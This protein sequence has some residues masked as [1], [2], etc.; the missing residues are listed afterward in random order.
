MISPPPMPATARPCSCSPSIPTSK[1]PD[2][3]AD[4]KPDSEPG[5]SDQEASG[6]HETLRVG[7]TNMYVGRNMMEKLS[8]Y[9]QVTDRGSR[10]LWCW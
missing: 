2:T 3:A 9:V 10:G 4:A 8:K 6:K 5:M 7:Y 1:R